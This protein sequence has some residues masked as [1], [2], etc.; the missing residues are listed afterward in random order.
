LEILTATAFIRRAALRTGT[1]PVAMGKV[2][3]YHDV[4]LMDV[5]DTRCWLCGGS[6]DGKGQPVKKAIKPT[7]TDIPLAKAQESKSVCAGC[8]FCLSF[9]SMR[10]YSIVA[11][12][13][14]L[15]HPSRAELRDILLS[16]PKPPFVTCIAVSGQ[17]WVHIKSQIV[18]TRNHFPVQ[19]EDITVYV[20]PVE[21]E[22][23]LEPIE[24]LYSAGFRKMS[25]KTFTGEI[26]TGQ[27]DSHKILVFGIEKWSELEEQ[28]K[29]ARGQ[30]LFKLA[31]FVAQKKGGDIIDI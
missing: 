2:V 16:P 20:E 12:E 13:K 27:Y 1:V 3:Q 11:T 21:F 7:F 14:I 5:N 4:P 24:E 31:L 19:L 25:G 30:R 28:I 29:E 18:Y 10:N 15:L 8:T 26:E 17:K 6:T 22:K 9:K 23:L